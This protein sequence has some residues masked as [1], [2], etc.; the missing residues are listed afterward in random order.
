M[1]LATHDM[2]EAQ[3]LCDRIAVIAR[4][5]LVATGT[6]GELAADGRLEDAIA[7]ITG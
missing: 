5:R 4:G 7:D 1:L 6:P 3:T 2:A